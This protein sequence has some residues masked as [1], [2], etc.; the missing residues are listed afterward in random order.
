MATDEKD[1]VPV[2]GSPLGVF[3]NAAYNLVVLLASDPVDAAAEVVGGTL[4][5]VP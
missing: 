1:P 5:S 4:A 2:G 3:D